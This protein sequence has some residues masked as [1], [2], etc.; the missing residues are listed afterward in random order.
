MSKPVYTFDLVNNLK[1][2][3]INADNRWGL[4]CSVR[5]LYRSK[6]GFWLWMILFEFVKSGAGFTSSA[7]LSP[8]FSEIW[9]KAATGPIP[10]TT[11]FLET[12]SPW[13]GMDTNSIHQKI[14]AG[15]SSTQSKPCPGTEL[16]IWL[17]FDLKTSGEIGRN[18]G[19]P[20]A[21]AKLARRQVKT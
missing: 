17:S 8:L 2:T 20:S 14:G 5:F 19:T 6:F 13:Y 4:R 18:R 11:T 16:Q 3:H 1:A 15:T 9:C 10:T 7:Y 21:L 12:A